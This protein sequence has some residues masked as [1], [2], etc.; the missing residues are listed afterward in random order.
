MMACTLNIQY[1]NTY[2]QLKNVHASQLIT[3]LNLI[4]HGQWTES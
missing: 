2:M 4:R 1:V 3:Q